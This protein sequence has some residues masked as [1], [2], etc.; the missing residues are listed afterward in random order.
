[1]DQVDAVVEDI[2]PVVRDAGHAE[3]LGEVADFHAAGDTADVVDL[4]EFVP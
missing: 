2:A 3:A 1:M 4:G